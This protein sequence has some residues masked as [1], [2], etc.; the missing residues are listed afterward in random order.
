MQPPSYAIQLPGAADLRFTEGSRLLPRLDSQALAAG[1]LHELPGTRLHAPPV[2]LVTHAAAAPTGPAPAPTTWLCVPRRAAATCCPLP[3]PRAAA[4]L[5][6]LGCPSCGAELSVSVIR[7][8]APEALQALEEALADAWLRDH[9]AIRCARRPPSWLP[10][11]RRAAHAAAFAAQP[12]AC[13]S[14]WV[15][16]TTQPCAAGRRHACRCPACSAIIERLPASPAEASC[17][18]R[19]GSLEAAQH[20]Q[21]HR[22]RCACGSTFCDGC[23]AVPYH[24]GYTCEQVRGSCRRTRGCG[25]HRQLLPRHQTGCS[26]DSAPTL[27]H[28]PPPTPPTLRPAEPG[29]RLHILCHQG[30]CRARQLIQH[31]PLLACGARPGGRPQRRCSF[32]AHGAGAE[33]RPRRRWGGCQLVPGEGGLAG[34]AQPHAAG[35]AGWVQAGAHWQ[36]MHRNGEML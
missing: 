24:Q 36:C 34:T 2:V 30:D 28:T 23:R 27:P 26:K 17:S 14:C 11:R 32:A 18:G 7:Q 13:C 12:P 31:T 5:P 25:R 22:F 4:G 6:T 16:S 10:P 9:N 8:L 29:T 21:R 19:E 1:G 35:A 15:H 33:R 3:L 20:M